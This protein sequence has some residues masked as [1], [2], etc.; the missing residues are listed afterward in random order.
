M[1]QDQSPH[2][3]AD[4]QRLEAEGLQALQ[5]RDF[6]RAR[7][8]LAQLT[9]LRTNN[10]A[11]WVHL[12]L[13]HRG[14]KDDA[15]EETALFNALKAD[16]HDLM[17][18][19]MRGN[20]FERQGRRHDAARAYQ[21]VR[22]VAPPVD[23]VVPH[24]RQGLIHAFEFADRYGQ[25]H[26]KFVDR[27]L[28]EV[29]DQFNG[30]MLDRFRLSMDILWGRKRRYES[31]PLGYFVPGL[32]PVEFFDRGLFPWLEAVEGYSDLI[33]QEF[34]NVLAS[35]DGFAPYVRQTAD[36]PL[37][38]WAELNHSPRWS[39]FHLLKEGLP[40]DGNAQRCP[41][42][43]EALSLAP[44]PAQEGRTPVALFSLL[45]PKTRIPPHNG[46]SNA[47]LLTHLPLIVPTGC[48][49]RVGNSVRE[50]VPGKAW[51]FDDTIEHEAWNDSNQLRVILIFDVWH[52]ALTEPEK[53]LITALAQA[54]EAFMGPST[55]NYSAG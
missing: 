45:K 29:A 4:L 38:Q 28:A 26:A 3:H 37:N 8:V 10:T 53:A 52:P 55:F 46:I 14:L 48:G 40:V 16:S 47:R 17:A 12:A 41:K 6:A 30:A 5:G 42:T 19:L 44:Q 49:F 1:S 11:D 9:H 7:N 36:Q 32:P 31:Q 13:A 25:E 20:L 50:W 22:M 43:L 39:A 33:R 34:L 23:Q 15:A 51:V 35:D 2:T 54:Q 27:Q 21:A 24:L 18:L